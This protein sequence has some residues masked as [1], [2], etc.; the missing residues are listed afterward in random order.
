MK[1]ELAAVSKRLFT[2]A[3]PRYFGKA[4][5]DQSNGTILIPVFIE[6]GGSPK[7]SMEPAT[8]NLYGMF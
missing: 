4:V 1:P 8:L 2:T 7:A 3:T 5:K 6:E